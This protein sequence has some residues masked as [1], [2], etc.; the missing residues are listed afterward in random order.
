MA[1][2]DTHELSEDVDAETVDPRDAAEGSLL[3]DL[4]QAR[5]AL[6][7]R[8]TEDFALPGFE[9]KLW[10]TCRLPKT[11]SHWHL[12]KRL[13]DDDTPDAQLTSASAELIAECTVGLWMLGPAGREDFGWCRRGRGSGSTRRRRGCCRCS[14]SAAGWFSGTRLRLPGGRR[15]AVAVARR[16]R[17]GNPWATGADDGRRSHRAWRGSAP[18]HHDVERRLSRADRRGA[19]RR[20]QG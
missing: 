5:E 14:I 9:G 16:M 2:L 20:R 15:R 13:A 10:A 3:D 8:Q 11:R 18:V 4:V 17:R 19:G 6:D 12:V 7:A 1:D